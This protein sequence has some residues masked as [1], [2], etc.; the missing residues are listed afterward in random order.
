MRRN[1]MVV[2]ALTASLLL[3]ACNSGG[4]ASSATGGTGGKIEGVTW[5][6]TSYVDG[7]TLK[8]VPAGV[9]ADAKFVN[10]NVSGSAGCNRYNG[11]AKI[12]GATIAVTGL[13]STKMACPPPASNV[14]DAYLADL[15][16]SATFTATADA[17]TI[18]DATGAKLLVY[19]AAPSGIATGVTWHAIGYNNGKQA[20]SLV[21]A[22]SDPTAVFA[23]DGTISGNATCNTYSGSYKIDGDKITIGPLASTMMAC[24]SEE[25]NAQEAAFLAAL[26]SATTYGVEGKTLELRDAAGA[27]QADFE[28]R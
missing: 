27:L 15:Q 28:Q 8:N 16:K 6:L 13:I 5:A 1:A 2:G 25:L 19:A 14:E 17:L 18:F 7:A 3:A 23:T 21:A 10:G 9:Y 24:A 22:G 26:Q 12:S 20:V 11:P 4:G